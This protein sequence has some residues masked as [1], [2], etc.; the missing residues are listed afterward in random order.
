MKLYVGWKVEGKHFYRHP[1]IIGFQL[2]NGTNFGLMQHIKLHRIF[3]LCILSMKML[4]KPLILFALFHFNRSAPFNEL[5]QL[6]Y[7]FVELQNEPT[8]I[9]AYVCWRK[10]DLV[11]F[12]ETFLKQNR[13]N[14]QVINPKD[15][16]LVYSF[17]EEH[18]MLIMDVSCTG[19][20][21]VFL[22]VEIVA[23]QMKMF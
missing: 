2:V 1:L 3:S 23:L 21:E 12:S 7:G 15:G 13:V 20:K 4:V 17:P 8:K 14:L 19:S 9:T 18:Q 6:I 16:R 11:Q 10:Q 5:T 22:K